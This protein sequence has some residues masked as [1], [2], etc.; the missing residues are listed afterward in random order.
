ML[1]PDVRTL[2]AISSLQNNPDFVVF[3]AWIER[4][5]VQFVD[6]T[7][8]DAVSP[9]SKHRVIQGMAANCRDIIETIRTVDEKLKAI[10]SGAKT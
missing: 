2:Q 3:H 7:I 1:K 9:D 4:S 5:Y 8:R 6:L 10:A